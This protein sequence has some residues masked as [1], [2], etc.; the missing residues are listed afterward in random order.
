MILSS[1]RV[2]KE[3]SEHAVFFDPDSPEQL[4]FILDK[5]S[6]LPPQERCL[7]SARAAHDATIKMKIFADEFAG[8]MELGATDS[9]R[10]GKTKFN[11][12]S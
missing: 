3:Q 8:L 6:P 4:A 1:L 12:K 5:F 9:G 7:F 11:R 2:Q 10:G